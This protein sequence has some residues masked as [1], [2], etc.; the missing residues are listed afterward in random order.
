MVKGAC[1]FWEGSFCS[2]RNNSDFH[3]QRAVPLAVGPLIFTNRMFTGDGRCSAL[4]SCYKEIQR[5][6]LWV[7]HSLFTLGRQVSG[8]GELSHCVFRLCSI[9]LLALSSA[10]K[11]S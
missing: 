6:K 9:R 4:Q 5:E 8:T 11:T 1:Y 7:P 10:L 2:L 3:F